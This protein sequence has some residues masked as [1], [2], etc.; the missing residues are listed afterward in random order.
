[1]IRSKSLR[2]FGSMVLASCLVFFQF[3]CQNE[4]QA[5]DN[6]D[7]NPPTT[8]SIKMALIL[9]T[10]GSMDGLIDQAKAQLWNVV[11]ELARAKCDGVRPT[12]QIAV[13]QYGNDG[14]P[15]SEGYIQMVQSLTSDLDEISK[16]L[17]ALSTNGGSEFC[18]QAI[19]SSL[20]QLDWNESPEDYKV[21]FIAGNEGFNQGSVD[22][23]FVCGIAKEKGIIVNT[24]HCGDFQA[25]IN[26][27][28][29]DG[30]DLTGGKYLSINQNSKTEYIPSPY[31]QQISNLNDSLNTTYIQ[32]GA[33]GFYGFSNMSSQDDNA[34]G[35]GLG[36]KVS[37]SVSKST[38]AYD[39]SGWDLVD[40]KKAKDFKLKE[41]ENSTLPKNMQSMTLVEKEKYVAAQS[42]KR[43]II[44]ND[45]AT[46]D[47]KR[48]KFLAAKNAENASK[49]QLGGA[50][51]STVREQAQ[52]LNFSFSES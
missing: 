8:K 2:K 26:G 14:L 33:N 38:A 24:I 50:L 22:Y 6:P 9:D 1:M 48:R 31:D 51:I 45:I 18:G 30:A 49:N 4:L 46:L 29:K 20:N 39:N 42:A 16:S 19:Q 23:K 44:K 21:I 25:G 43:T 40:A 35:Y 7:D 34:S 52:N 12:M 13:Y 3:A 27:Y 17:F 10:S 37:R 32:Y 36:N 15:A 11:N 28:W 47:E 5:Q 41:V